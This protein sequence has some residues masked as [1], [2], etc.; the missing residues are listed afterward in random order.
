MAWSIQPPPGTC[1]G[2]RHQVRSLG[3]PGQSM[4]APRSEARWMAVAEM[5]VPMRPSLIHSL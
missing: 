5:G 1:A 3:R 4:L 2:S